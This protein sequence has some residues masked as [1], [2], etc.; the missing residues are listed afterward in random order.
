MGT[1]KWNK[2][3]FDSAV[4]EKNQI[5]IEMSPEYKEFIEYLKKLENIRFEYIRKMTGYEFWTER[6]YEKIIIRKK[7]TKNKNWASVN[8]T[9]L[10]KKK[11]RKPN[12]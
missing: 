2:R 6:E 12:R 8:E 4:I 11:K 9:K 1:K 7:I 10:L 5:E 3:K